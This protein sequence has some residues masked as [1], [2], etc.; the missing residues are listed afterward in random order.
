MMFLD[1]KKASDKNQWLQGEQQLMGV[2]G[3]S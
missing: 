2:S 1:T 3:T